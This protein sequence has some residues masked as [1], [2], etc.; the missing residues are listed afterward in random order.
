MIKPV[1]RAAGIA[2][3]I[4]GMASPLAAQ[5]NTFV[6]GTRFVSPDVVTDF[7]TGGSEMVGMRVTWS[8]TDGS[9]A[10]D[11]WRSLSPGT[12]GVS[13]GGF[14]VINSSDN[15]FGGAWSVRNFSNRIV[16]SVRFNGA[17]GR[18]LFDCAWNGTRCDNTGSRGDDL[19]NPT[20][21]SAGGASHT[22][23]GG[24]YTGAV[25]GEYA[26]LIGIGGAAPVGD[27][28]EQLTI[29]FAAGLGV[30]GTYDFRADTD[31]SD[32]NAPPPTSVPEPTAFALLAVGAAG[33]ASVAR[34]RRVA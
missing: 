19:L 26:N 25:F 31:N 1:F 27:L 14:E 13:G 10:F 20:V 9:S 18:T 11:F 5:T 22:Q 6:A 29:S 7:T 8:F 28:F 16:S 4:V 30:Q 15:T 3:V 34:R 32:F 21:G 12:W 23:V 2:A 17:S 33:L 24:S